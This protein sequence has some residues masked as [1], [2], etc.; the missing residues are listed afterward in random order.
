LAG[1]N[2]IALLNDAG[3]WE[4]IGFAEAE[5]VA[6]AT[7]E[8]THLLRGQMGTDYASGAASAGNRVV[9]LDD[10]VTSLAPSAAWLGTTRTLRSFAGPNDSTGETFDLA[11]DLD[12]LLPLAPVHL[13]ARRVA[14]GDISLGWMRRSRAD[15]DSWAP[16]DAPLDWA[17]EAYRVEIYDGASLVRTIEASASAATYTAAQQATDFGGPAASFTWRVAQHSAL[18]GPGHWA[19]ATYVS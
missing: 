7:Y 17:P 19:G 5:L 8:L 13:K 11:L 6:P 16:D 4:V 1:A 18:Y 10:A 14:G 15:T 9:V 12:T 3:D 2:R